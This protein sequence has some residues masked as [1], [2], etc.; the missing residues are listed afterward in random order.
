MPESELE[1]LREFLKE[2]L[3]KYLF[4]LQLLQYKVQ[5]FL[6]K[7]EDGFLRLCVDYKGLNNITLKIWYPLPTIQETLDRTEKAIVYTKLDLRG[8]YNLLR[9]KAGEE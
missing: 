8:V 7:K 6:L 4:S 2:N 3:S 1:T 5:F 9:I